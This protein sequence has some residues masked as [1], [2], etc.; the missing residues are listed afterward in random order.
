LGAQEGAFEL[1]RGAFVDGDEEK[2]LPSFGIFADNDY[3]CN[4]FRKAIL[5]YQTYA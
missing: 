2:E 1:A 4:R 5:K 3:F